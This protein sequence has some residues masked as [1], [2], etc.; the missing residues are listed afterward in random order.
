MA[1]DCRS[2]GSPARGSSWRTGI[3]PCGIGREFVVKG[4]CMA[5]R[6]LACMH[7]FFQL[8]HIYKSCMASWEPRMV[9]LCLLCISNHAL[10]VIEQPRQSL[11]YNY[12]RWQWLENR[13]CWVP[14]VHPDLHD[15][16]CMHACIYIYFWHPAAPQV[17]QVA[18]W[19]MKYGSPSPKR[20]LLRS[21]WATIT[22]MDL[23]RLT[24]TQAAAQTT[25]KTSCL[26]PNMQSCNIMHA[27]MHVPC[28]IEAVMALI[29]RSGVARRL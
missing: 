1:P 14:C 27:C 10:F 17:Y 7:V 3:N 6:I 24:R 26:G 13:V 16:M 9:L 25:V 12:F 15:H 22:Q 23:G 11:L 28:M 29:K 5:S 18:F 20:L 2:W 19:L 21:N 4:N 8:G